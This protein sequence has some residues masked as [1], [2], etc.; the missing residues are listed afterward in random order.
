MGG[1]AFIVIGPDAEEQMEPFR[2]FDGYV[3]K[4]VRSIDIL[5]ET[6]EDFADSQ[7]GLSPATSM[8]FES[9]V[10]ERRSLG[11]IL[12][13][14]ETPDFLDKDRFGWVRLDEAG[15]V[16]EIFHRDRPYSFWVN[17]GVLATSWMLKPG[18]AATSTIAS[19]RISGSST[20]GYTGSALK[21]EIDWKKMRGDI[22]EEAGEYWDLSAAG[23]PLPTHTRLSYAGLSR[24]IFLQYPREKFVQVNVDMLINRSALIMNGK[25][26]D[27][28]DFNGW[29]NI[30]SKNEA[31]YRY[32]N[33]L[34]DSLPDDTLMTDVYTRD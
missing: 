17:W 24:N 23:M 10:R 2:S 27:D 4:H 18:I 29:G 6:L 15:K 33:E 3:D 34:I 9:Y 26:I 16:S 7:S 31:W 30:A 28:Q 21:R 11:R 1:R 19:D 25:V 5:Q 32:L 20:P 22:A 13:P 14:G 12:K 8:S